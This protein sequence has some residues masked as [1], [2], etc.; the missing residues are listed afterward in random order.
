VNRHIEKPEKRTKRH[1][2]H[3]HVIFRTKTPELGD[4]MIF[5]DVIDKIWF[6][7]INSSSIW[8]PFTTTAPGWLAP[9]NLTAF[10]FLI[11]KEYVSA[12]P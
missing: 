1:H 7:C 4:V 6:P 12:L 10:W 5:L 8:L 11:R 3:V 2:S 9:Q